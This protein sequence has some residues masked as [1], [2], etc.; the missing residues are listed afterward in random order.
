MSDKEKKIEN[1]KTNMEIE[2]MILE[3]QQIEVMKN[4]L[5]KKLTI[6]NAIKNIIKKYK[7]V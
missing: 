1:I 3:E 5:D 4:I 2:G 7:V 6:E